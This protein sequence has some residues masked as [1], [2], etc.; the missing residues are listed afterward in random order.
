MNADA[1]MAPNEKLQK[2]EMLKPMRR[3]RDM[4]GEKKMHKKL[5][6]VKRVVDARTRNGK[7]EYLLAREDT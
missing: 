1:G 2:Q 3:K 7:R 4:K 5:Y 6:A